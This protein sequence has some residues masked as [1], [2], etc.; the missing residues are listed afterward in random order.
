MNQRRAPVI[1][2]DGPSGSGKGTIS[3]LLATKLGFHYLDSGALYRLVALAAHRHRVAFDNIEGLAVL[4]AHIDITFAVSSEGSFPKVILEGEDVSRLIRTESAGAEASTVAA[5]PAVRSALLQRQ[6]AFACE[7]GLVADGRDMGTVVFP[8][9]EV[10]VF[11]TA[12][13]EVRAERRYNQLIGKGETVSLADLV[14][15][16]RARDEQDQNRLVS[17][18]RPA[19]DAQLL[20]SSTMAVAEVLAAVWAMVSKRLAI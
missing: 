13:P 19:Q 4:A 18:L 5:I 2:I 17:P 16:V 9:A 8:D 12:A 10:K 7:P 6:R 20:D 14:E 11:L 3:Q 15:K 1:T